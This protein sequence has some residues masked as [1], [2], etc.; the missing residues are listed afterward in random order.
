VFLGL[1]ATICG[2]AGSA[3][4]NAADVT[5]LFMQSCVSFVGNRQG[6][7]DWAASNGLHEL[8]P[9]GEQAFLYGAPGKV[10]DA[11]DATGKFVVVSPDSGACSTI[12]EIA[13]GAAVL[14]QLERA[15]H[16]AGIAI[17]VTKDADDSAEKSLHHRDYVASKD[18]L[19]WRILV[20][21]VGDKPGTA[22]LTATP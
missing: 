6:L 15:L 2:A 16:A 1:A 13:D 9:E 4:D 5:G 22:M 20:G 18:R 12:A 17:Q 21:T 19:Q 11:T 10:F 7:R 8:P 14:D 3:Q